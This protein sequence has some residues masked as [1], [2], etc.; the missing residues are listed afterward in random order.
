M[1]NVEVVAVPWKS[2]LLECPFANAVAG[3]GP[4]AGGPVRLLHSGQTCRNRWAERGF[5]TDDQR[6]AV[7]G[8]R[9]FPAITLSRRFVYYLHEQRPG[10]LAQVGAGD[11]AASVGP[12]IRRFVRPM[13]NL[14][15]RV[16]DRLSL[17]GRTNGGRPIVARI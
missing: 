15:G 2:Q 10:S 13:K 17:P 1:N 6:G 11:L 4:G 7:T 9:V 5:R 16:D 12:H 14:D 3:D 8:L